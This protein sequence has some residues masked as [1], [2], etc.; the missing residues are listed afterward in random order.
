MSRKYLLVFSCTT[1]LSFM[2]A[3]RFHSYTL[4]D[5]KV[6]NASIRSHGDVLLFGNSVNNH[7]SLC[8]ID[9]RSI[10]EIMN[11][12]KMKVIDASRPGMQLN[13]MLDITKIISS[14]GIKPKTIVIPASPESG[15]FD[16]GISSY[17][18]WN[19]FL[20][21]N[22]PQFLM[23]SKHKTSITPTEYKG[24]YFGNYSQFSKKY[25]GAEKSNA[26]CPEHAGE[27]KAFFE[28]MY[29]RNFL[30]HTNHIDGI[31]QYIDQVK[32]I[33]TGG[34]K[35]ITLFMPVNFGDIHYLFGDAE[36]AKVV[37]DV[38]DV[39][40]ALSESGLDVINASEKVSSEYFV[41]RWC[42]CGHLGEQ[43]RYIVAESISDAID[44]IQYD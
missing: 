25:F 43:G 30:Q 16:K 23:L 24:Q 37:K 14:L 28:F 7:S 38:N 44:H 11:T 34:V 33:Q 15:F 22:L 17:V 42:A 36:A 3:V 2:L 40:Q 18:G 10:S 5:F 8:D 39:V 9:H 26:T 13:T 29:W 41:D 31:N 6:L 12:Q 35:V 4:S 21:K 20:S 32:A 1:L 19:G 27:N